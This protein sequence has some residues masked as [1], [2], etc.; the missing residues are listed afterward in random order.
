MSIEATLERIAAS[1]ETIVVNM[2][3]VKEPKARPVHHAEPTPTPDFAFVPPVETPQVPD[4]AQSFAPAAPEKPSA[5]FSDAA[6]VMAYIMS[7]YKA[8]GP[9][10]GALIQ[11]AL[12]ELGHA[13]ISGLRPDQYGE[14]YV[15]VEAIV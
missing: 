15:K 2:T 14:F 1:L 13:N 6:G 8:L 5:P 11:Q 3:Q 12:T 7:R 4:F 10:K 9:V